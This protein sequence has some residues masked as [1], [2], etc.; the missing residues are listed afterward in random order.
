MVVNTCNPSSQEAEE[1]G[2]QVQ[3][4]KARPCLKQKK[5]EEKHLPINVLIK[6]ILIKVNK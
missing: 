5:R 1:G 2:L 3:G 4:Y 6:T